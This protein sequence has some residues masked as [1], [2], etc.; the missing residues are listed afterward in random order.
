MGYKYMVVFGDMH[1][2][3]YDNYDEAVKAVKE[4]NE[5][6]NRDS[7]ILARVE[8]ITDYS[9]YEEIDSIWYF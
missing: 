4:R 5:N 6:V 8:P 7:E 9:E 1:K 3:I 2:D